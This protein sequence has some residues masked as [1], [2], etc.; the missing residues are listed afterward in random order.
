MK[1]RNCNSWACDIRNDPDI[2]LKSPIRIFCVYETLLKAARVQL[3]SRIARPCYAKHVI[4]LAADLPSIDYCRSVPKHTCGYTLTYAPQDTLGGWSYVTITIVI[5][6]L[7]ASCHILRHPF[8][9]HSSYMVVE[10]RAHRSMI[11]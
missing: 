8:S 10:F 5:K 2:T 3:E 6:F 4:N 1:G 11:I 9:S 7:E